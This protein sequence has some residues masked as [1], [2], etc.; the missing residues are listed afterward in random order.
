MAP[1]RP[2]GIGKALKRKKLNAEERK[3]EGISAPTEIEVQLSSTAD[4]DDELD[5]LRAL[6]LTFLDASDNELVLNG[7][8]HE[9]DRLLRND[10]E[11]ESKLGD[12]F[13]AIYALALSRLAS[14]TQDNSEVGDYFEAALERVTLGLERFPKSAKLL[15]ARAAIILSRI[16]LQYVSQMDLDT[17]ISK[18]VPKMGLLVDEAL[19][20]YSEAESVA[21]LADFDAQT[22]DVLDALDDLLDLAKHYGNDEM[23]HGMDSDDEDEDDS[24]DEGGLAETHPLKS[25]KDS[26]YNEHWR[27]HTLTFLAKLDEKASG[28]DVELKRSVLKKLGQFYLLESETP[29]SI[30]ISLAFGEG[31]DEATQDAKTAQKDAKRFTKTAVDYLIRA[32]NPDD[33]QSLV[34]VAEAKISLGNLYP[35][36]GEDQERLYNEA[37][38]LLETANKATHGKY[39]N[40]LENL[41]GE[42]AD[43]TSV[44]A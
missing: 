34:D 8:V 1:K 33:P 42:N 25:L 6:W 5:Q 13:H 18:K 22:F 38:A 40:I 39:D 14:F 28:E 16:P 15:F 24:A 7:V 23:E 44:N 2:L 41:R 37:E 19:Q 9:C 17:Q 12:D 20:A 32:Q 43:M 3:E 29:A 26:K 27:D 21:E 31:A 11:S 10:T 35:L 36:E 4:A 30:Y